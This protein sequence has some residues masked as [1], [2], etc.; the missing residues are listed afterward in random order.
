MRGYTDAFD[1]FWLFIGFFHLDL[2]PGRVGIPQSKLSKYEKFEGPDPAE[3]AARGY[4]IVNV[5]VRG[6]WDSEGGS[7]P[8][9]L[10][11]C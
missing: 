3:W 8:Y 5:D 9:V 1:P 2:V 6:S 4:A 11:N 7:L 10:S